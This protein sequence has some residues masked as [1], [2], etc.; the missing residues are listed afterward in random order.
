MLNRLVYVSRS[1][2]LLL[3]RNLPLK[4]SEPGPEFLPIMLK[5]TDLNSCPGPEF[6]LKTTCFIFSQLDPQ[7]SQSAYRGWGRDAEEWLEHDRK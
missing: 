4:H 6:L 7:R 1:S 3:M 2:R 5:H